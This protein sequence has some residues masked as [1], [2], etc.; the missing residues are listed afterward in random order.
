MTRPEVHDGWP[1]SPGSRPGPGPR[2]FVLLPG[3]GGAATWYW[4]RVIPLLRDAGHE[5][6]PVDLPG[7]D[8]AAGLPA[9]ARLAAAAIGGH[10]NAVLVAH[11]LGA[12]TAPMAAAQSRVAGIVLVNAMIPEPGETP[13]AW[14]DNTG[15]PQA[16]AAAARHGG[17]STTFDLHTY[18]LHDVPADIAATGQDWPEE[19]AVFE[20]ACDFRAWPP[21]PVKVVAGA[22]DR[23]FPLGFQQRLARD[24]LGVEAD[25]LPGGHLIA[26]AQPEAMARY[27]LTA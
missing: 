22:G 20:S 24:R 14:W 4:Q 3:S 5:A 19:D 25:V 2:R 13:G 10:H 26:L 6:V 9:Y 15:Q 21:V 12:F 27:L 23:L 8:P 11:S 1:A 7:A 16:Q 17:Y 18:F